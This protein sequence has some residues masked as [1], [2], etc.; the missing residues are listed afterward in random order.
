MTS[1]PGKERKIVYSFCGPNVNI[2]RKGK[3]MNDLNEE[4]E[5]GGK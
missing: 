5:K 3:V 2:L 1:R 4:L